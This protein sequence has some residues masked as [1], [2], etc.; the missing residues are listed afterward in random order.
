M[1]P[2]GGVGGGVEDEAE[3]VFV[4]DYGVQAG[5]RFL[6]SLKSL[7]ILALEFLGRS[8]NREE[9]ERLLFSWISRYFRKKK[10]SCLYLTIN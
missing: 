2:W 1:L 4:N 10:K 3:H 6:G 5:N 7:Q 9:A 8:R